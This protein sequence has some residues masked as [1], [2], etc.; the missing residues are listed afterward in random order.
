[1]QTEKLKAIVSGE[2]TGEVAAE[3]LRAA[4]ADHQAAEEGA[5]QLAILIGR[6]EVALIYGGAGRPTPPKAEMFVFSEGV[7]TGITLCLAS[8]RESK[9]IWTEDLAAI[10]AVREWADE[11]DASRQLGQPAAITAKLSAALAS[12]EVAR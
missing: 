9:S 4:I 1:M 2:I 3:V 12:L 10:A 5:R 8:K 6:A 11:M 7:G